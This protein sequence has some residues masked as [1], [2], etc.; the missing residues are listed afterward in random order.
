MKMCLEMKNKDDFLDGFV[1]QPP[2]NDPLFPFWKC[3]NT[4]I[5]G[6]ILWTVSLEIAQSILLVPPAAKA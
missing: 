1:V 2:P 5:L 3:C 4:L 6:W